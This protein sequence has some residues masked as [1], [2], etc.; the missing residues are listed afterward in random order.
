MNPNPCTNCGSTKGT[1]ARGLCMKCYR[2][3]ERGVPMDKPDRAP[4]GKATAFSIRAALDR[5]ARWEKAAKKAKQPFR[6]WVR[7]VLDEAADKLIP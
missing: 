4:V 3:E 2:R 5:V 7:G 6:D 1:V